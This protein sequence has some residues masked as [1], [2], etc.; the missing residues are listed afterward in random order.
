MK[1]FNSYTA[2]LEEFTPIEENKVKISV[3]NH[4]LRNVQGKQQ[5]KQEILQEEK[6]RLK[7]HHFLVNL[8]IVLIRTLRTVKFSS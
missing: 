7:A 2:K 5:E 1:L 8:Q 6:Q 3:K 4:F